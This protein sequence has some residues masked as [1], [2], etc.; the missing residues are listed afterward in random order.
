MDGKGGQS[1]N[2]IV[3]PSRSRRAIEPSE[4]DKLPP[5]DEQAERDALGCAL[6][7]P[8]L[9]SQLE[10]RHFLPPVTK[11]S[12]ALA[13]VSKQMDVILTVLNCAKG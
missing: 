5:Y 8:E 10:F 4:S 2:G 11:S 6:E 7:K 13:Q 1:P 9:F 3:R 12:S